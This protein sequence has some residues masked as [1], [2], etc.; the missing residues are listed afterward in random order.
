M[1]RLRVLLTG[2]AG[3]IGTMFRAAVADRYD[4][5]CLDRIPTPGVSG[6]VVADLA[7]AAA[8]RRAAEG[9]DAILHLGGHP[10]PADFRTVI[11]PSNVV[12]TYHVFEAAKAAK[13]RRVVFAS[14]VQVDFG[15]PAPKI[16]V[17]MAPQPTNVY[18]ASKVFG[19]HLGRI[20]SAKHGLEVVC[21]RLGHVGVPSRVPGMLPWGVFPSRIVLTAHDAVEILTRALERPGIAFA[22]LPAFSR[23]A[24][25]IRDLTPLKAVLDYEPCEDAFA[26]WTK[27]RVPLWRRPWGWVRR[28]R[29]K[30]RMFGWSHPAGKWLRWRRRARPVRKVLVTGA[31]GYVGTALRQALAGRFE[32]VCLDRRPVPGVPEACVA[33]LA[34]RRALRRA[35][36]GCDAVIHLGGVRDDADFMAELLPHNIE[37]TWNVYESAAAAGVRRILF[38]STLQAEEGLPRD[39][40]ASVTHPARPMNLYAVTKVLGEDLGRAV[41]M[42][43]GIAVVALRLGWVRV[44]EDPEWIA[45]EGKRP[46]AITL[47]IPDLARIIEAA[48]TKPLPPFSLLPAY[49]RSAIGRKD[50][51]PLQEALGVEP[52]DDP[53]AEWNAAHPEQ[54]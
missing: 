52:Q 21:V 17:E 54:A 53:V 18:G 19:E 50:L 20:A 24:A 16:S 43:T 14:T 36:R 8:L 6:A 4:F 15:N 12:G 33:G 45:M 37:G 38:A 9:C 3:G 13:V 51:S 42:R 25:E 35:M 2:S 5:V 22:I 47:T 48:L 28:Q 39:I 23:N 44:P 32:F 1:A 11:L 10:V 31:A 27:Q 26:L 30:R 34:D 7:D 41:A 46:P 29:F 40:P 49:S